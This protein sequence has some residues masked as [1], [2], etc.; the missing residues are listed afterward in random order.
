MVENGPHHSTSMIPQFSTGTTSG[1]P[2]NGTDQIFGEARDFAS[3][4][5]LASLSRLKAGPR[6]AAPCAGPSECLNRKGARVLPYACAKS[7][8][9]PRVISQEL[10]SHCISQFFGEQQNGKPNGR[11]Q[12]WLEQMT[13]IVRL[14]P[15]S[16][17]F[18][19]N[20]RS[21]RHPPG[22]VRP[23]GPVNIHG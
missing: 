5:A 22:I 13:Q 21:D 2:T 18:I 10:C 4:P 3:S 19:P 9:G 16:T 7:P 15:G 8:R 23:G 20:H 12:H 11:T 6:R 1:P 17:R 14:R